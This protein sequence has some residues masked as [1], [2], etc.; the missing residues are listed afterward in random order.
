MGGEK[1]YYQGQKGMV[2]SRGDRDMLRCWVEL[3]IT[4]TGH[5]G[6]QSCGGGQGTHTELS[7]ELFCA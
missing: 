1:R 6:D 4:Q 2:V 3:A 5:P 7:A